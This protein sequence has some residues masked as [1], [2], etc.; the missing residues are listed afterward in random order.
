MDVD[1]L[2]GELRRI[3]AA[4]DATPVHELWQLS[5]T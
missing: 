1:K 4:M 3:G 5:K 2:I